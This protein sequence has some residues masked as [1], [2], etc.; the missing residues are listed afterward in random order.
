VEG[1]TIPAGFVWDQ[2]MNELEIVTS[3]PTPDNVTPVV[4]PLSFLIYPFVFPHLSAFSQRLYL[5]DA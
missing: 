5:V 1:N 2:S 3:W 4:R